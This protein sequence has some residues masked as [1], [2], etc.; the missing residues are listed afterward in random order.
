MADNILPVHGI[1]PVQGADLISVRSRVNWGPIVAGAMVTFAVTLVLGLLAT[2]LGLSL[3]GGERPE[4]LKTGALISA[5]VIAAIAFFAGGG[6]TTHLTVGENNGEAILHGVV[7]SGVAF[8]ILFVLAAAGVRAGMSSIADLVTTGDVASR[9]ATLHNGQTLDRPVR[10]SQDASEK[11][12]YG[13]SAMKANMNEASTNPAQQQAMVQ[14]A[15]NTAWWAFLGVV[16]A[17]AAGIIGALTGAG[18]TF[19]LRRIHT[20]IHRVPH[21]PQPATR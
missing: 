8:V 14:S 15:S 18:R 16:V 5:L 21:R 12:L 10:L 7:T 2:A 3:S 17:I 11:W 13:L 19:R 6:T 20:I 9:H 4:N 1:A